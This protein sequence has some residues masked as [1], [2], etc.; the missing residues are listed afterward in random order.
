MPRII[1][2]ETK[3][4]A[5]LKVYSVYNKEAHEKPGHSGLTYTKVTL[6]FYEMRGLAGKLP[7]PVIVP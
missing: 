3:A 5:Y 1:F 2:L 7:L 4:L 6:V